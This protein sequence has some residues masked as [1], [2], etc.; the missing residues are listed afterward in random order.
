MA[1]MTTVRHRS[2]LRAALASAAAAAALLLAAAPALAQEPGA[3]GLQSFPPPLAGPP[4]S[5]SAPRAEPPQHGSAP[6]FEEQ[7]LE[8]VNQERLANGGL[9]PLKGQTQ[10]A[11][12]AELHSTNMGTRNF[13]SHCDPDLMT[14]PGQR[15]TAAGYIWSSVGENAAAGQTTPQ[16]VMAAW[17]G[18]AGHRANILSGNF[19]ELGVG[20]FLDAADAAN[21]RM[22]LDSNC[23]SEGTDGPF[24]H[25]WTQNFGR[26]NDVYPVV[27]EREA[28]S[29]AT[30]NVDLH[31]YGTG[32][33]Q[34]MRLRNETGTF[35]A[36]MPFSSSAAWQL[37]VGGGIKTVTA[38]LRNGATVR[39][40]TD[41]ILLEGAA[42]VVFDDGFES[43]NT[44]AWS[45]TVP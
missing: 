26:R 33:A 14:M 17:M 28:F 15:V 38:E 16:N 29:T 35:T 12:A 2:I 45:N 3:E 43:G 4:A 24:V 6:T 34:E 40:A 21:V 32:W 39:S 13:F 20:Y 37:T 36:W 9:P 31:L 22:D 44:S 1:G 5:A 8:R 7:V 19:R 23:V 25:Y 41:S 30:R 11:A 10:L 18:S 27:I 42:Q